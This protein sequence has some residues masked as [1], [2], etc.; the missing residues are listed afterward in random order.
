MMFEAYVRHVILIFVATV[1]LIRTPAMVRD[2]HQRP[3]WLIL[4]AFG[5]GSIVIQPWFGAAVNRM[6]GVSQLNNLIQ[7]I[8]GVLNIAVTLEF[9]LILA[10]SGSRSAR[11]RTGR[12]AL[13]FATA[14]G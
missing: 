6:T 10:N 13:A 11:G 4:V 8:W 5:G 14:A 9:A 12:V 1:L 3:L 7:G 2:Q